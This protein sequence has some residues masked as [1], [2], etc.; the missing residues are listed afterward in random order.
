MQDEYDP[1]EEYINAVETQARVQGI[2][3]ELA[4]IRVDQSGD[5]DVLRVLYKDGPTESD[6]AGLQ[7]TLPPEEKRAQEG[8]PVIRDKIDN[9][10]ESLREHL[11]EDDSEDES[12]DNPADATEED[13]DTTQDT[14]TQSKRSVQDA[15]AEA[16][17]RDSTRTRKSIT[18]DIKTQ[19]DDETRD[20]IT[21][22]MDELQDAVNDSDHEER[23]SDLE[24][25]IGEIE[26]KLSILAE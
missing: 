5:S 26:E 3:D 22:A 1:F 18:L 10:I 6:Q 7:I 17:Q 11:T 19:L 8:V 23:I 25:R 24:E 9:G 16:A 20:E 15:V 4:D 2:Y 12:E 21:G 14:E 13:T